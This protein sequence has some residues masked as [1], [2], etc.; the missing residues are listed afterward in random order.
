MSSTSVPTD[1]L[2]TGSV[3][4]R[5]AELAYVRRGY[6]VVARNW[7][8]RVGELDLVV[9]RDGVVAICEVKTRRGRRFG[10][11]W[12]AV[13]ARKQAKLRSVAQAFLIA[14]DVRPGAVRFD[15]A[16]VTLRGGDAIVSVYEDAF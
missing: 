2:V 6:R 13:D 5:A 14:T 12:Q 8:C 10:E 1:R 11:P 15:V 9:V 4:E 3:G 7:R 16:S